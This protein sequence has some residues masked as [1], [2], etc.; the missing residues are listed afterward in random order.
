LNDSEPPPPFTGGGAG[1]GT[2]VTVVLPV[3]ELFAATKSVVVLLTV[4]VDTSVPAAAAVALTVTVTD[5]AAA[6]SPM[7]QVSS[8]DVPAVQLAPDAVPG[9]SPCASWKVNWDAAATLGSLTRCF[10]KRLLFCFSWP[11][12]DSVAGFPRPDH[13]PSGYMNG[14]TPVPA[15]NLVTAGNAA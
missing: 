1:G 12:P 6:R 10:G 14:N 7:A 2:A 13:R 11:A 8:P 4:A 9:V 3:A 15:P 5:F